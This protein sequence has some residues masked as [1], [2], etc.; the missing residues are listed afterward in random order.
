PYFYN[1]L[2]TSTGSVK[3]ALYWFYKETAKNDGAYAYLDG[4]FN[5][6]SIHHSLTF[7]G[8]FG[9]EKF[10]SGPVYFIMNSPVNDINS[11]HQ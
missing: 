11:F 7:G 1:Y 8:S 9:S 5:T 3:N 10:Y 6:G 4:D 2:N